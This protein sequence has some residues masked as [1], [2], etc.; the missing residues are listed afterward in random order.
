[1]R[2]TA[3]DL[4]VLLAYMAALTWLGLHFSGRQ[5]TRE[6]YLLGDRNVHWLLAGGSILATLVSSITYLSAPGEMIR[7]GVTYFYG[8]LALPLAIPVITR[9]LM[10]MVKRLE[11]AS[12]YGYLETRFEWRVRSLA[13]FVFVARTFL[14]MALI[15]YTCALPVAEMTGWGIYVTVLVMGV[16]TTFYTSIG[17]LRT[18]IW[19]DNLQL[20]ILFG[21]ALAIPLFVWLSIGSSPLAWIRDFS[22]AGRTHIE[23]FS[24]DPTVRTTVAGAMLAQFFWNVCT[25]GADQV[26]VQRYLSTPSI[27]SARRSVWVFALFNM[28]L[29]LALMLCGLA[30]FAFY[31]Q[32][33]GSPVEAFQQEI[34]ARADRVMPMFIVQ[35]LPPGLAGL[36]LAAVLAAAMSSLSSGINA[37]CGVVVADWLE[38]F[39]LFAEH[40]KTLR[41]DKLV[42]ALAGAVGTG[43][44]IAMAAAVGRTRWNL[45]E[46][47]GRVNHV[48]VGPLA[49]LVFAGI[50]FKRSG[51]SSALA[52]FGLGLATSLFVSF[53]GELFGLA[54]SPSFLLVVPASFLVGL[55]CAGSLS[56]LSPC[57]ARGG[58]S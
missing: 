6:E 30:L 48:F 20:L 8:I 33:A 42:S 19:T 26:A 25:H 15:I 55:A 10:P 51:T 9:V 5:T 18:V 16:V 13:S 17:G 46:L 57:A 7:Y 45:V 54:R 32:R 3:L 14:W 28:I 47:T 53:G 2:I 50:L 4:G 34:A 58:P 44:A 23:G 39:G 21:G 36:L 29:L 52:G 41:A 27:Q 35:E 40:L 37:V 43:I 11:V 49:V 12:V 22:A 31:F 24:L 56:L 1:M 38:R